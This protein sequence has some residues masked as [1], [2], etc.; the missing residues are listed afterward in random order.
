M[1]SN[2]DQDFRS[3]NGLYDLIQSEHN[4][5]IAS[6]TESPVLNIASGKDLFDSSL[7]KNPSCTATFYKFIASM[8]RKIRTEVRST[9]ATHR[10]IRQ[11][12]DQRRLV[13]C[14]TQ[15][16]DGLEAREGL[17]VDLDRG[18]G[19]LTR[20][21]KRAMQL[22]KGAGD[23]Q[24]GSTLDGGCEAVQLHG[25]LEVLRCTI[26]REISIWTEGIID[27][28]FLMGKAPQCGFC[29]DRDRNRR[30]WGKRGSAIG[31][32]R[33]NIVLYGEE[34]PLAD[35]L[36]LITTH[37]LKLGPDVILI[38]GTS[39]KVHGLKVL[40]KEFAK[41]THGKGGTKGTV[42]FVNLTKPAESVWNNVIDYWVCMDCDAW[43]EDLHMRRPEIG[44]IQESLK[45]NITK[46]NPSKVMFDQAEKSIEN[47]EEKEN[48]LVTIISQELQTKSI[49]KPAGALSELV[50]GQIQNK[51]TPSKIYQFP[52]PPPSRNHVQGT[53]RVRQVLKHSEEDA[54][55]IETPSKRRKITVCVWDDDAGHNR[56]GTGEFQRN[57]HGDM[58][59]T[60]DSQH[61]SSGE[62]GLLEEAPEETERKQDRSKKR[63]L[64]MKVKEEV[65]A[66][67]LSAMTRQ[68]KRI[69]VV[70]SMSCTGTF[71]VSA[72]DTEQ[73]GTIRRGQQRDRVMEVRVPLDSGITST[74]SQLQ[75]K[76]K[77]G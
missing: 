7:W 42:V 8:R 22:P 3:T 70:G 46:E 15:N 35:S 66:E 21:S 9:T 13:R 76:R 2:F 67:N 52:T 30:D 36:A 54:L 51:S 6:S 32:L 5:P 48:A 55:L 61:I 49:R 38:L 12:R 16:I 37:D 19:S 72:N 24:K 53:G 26:C 43:V 56:H 65:H 68:D 28:A 4:S 17:C 45:L 73:E 23:S 77:R 41:A 59:Q 10:F 63:I 40:V 33:P 27:T 11:L 74:V 47:K 62:E 18:K 60:P 44:L 69:G 34:H 25:D 14:Y 64:D 71:G 1:G 20:F 58:M 29:V 50:A 31:S 57:S 39:L 75:R